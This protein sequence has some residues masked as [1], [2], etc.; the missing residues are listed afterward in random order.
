MEFLFFWGCIIFKT[1]LS[2]NALY[3]SSQRRAMEPKV[4]AINDFDDIQLYFFDN[5][6]EIKP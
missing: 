5:K 6:G 2:V 4:K 3:T 1:G